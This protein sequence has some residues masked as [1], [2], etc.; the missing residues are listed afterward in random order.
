MSIRRVWVGV[1]LH[2]SRGRLVGHTPWVA[3]DG[4]ALRRGRSLVQAHSA[5]QSH[6]LG[7]LI[8]HFGARAIAALARCVVTPS[9]PALLV[10]AVGLAAGQSSVGRAASLRAVRLSSI[11]AR[12]QVEEL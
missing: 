11:T 4:G 5:R 9:L 3:L 12:A 10:A 7:T 8:R 2:S 6:F 1:G